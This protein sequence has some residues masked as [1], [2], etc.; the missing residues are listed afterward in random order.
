MTT[1]SP[2]DARTTRRD[3]PGPEPAGAEPPTVEPP[4]TEPHTTEPP[5]GASS[6]GETP[7]SRR[8]EETSDLETTATRRQG[9]LGLRGDDDTRVAREDAAAGEAT[10]TMPAAGAH[11]APGTART[12][13][14]A[15]LRER[16]R[17]RPETDGLLDG[18]TQAAPRSRAAAHWWSLL[19][20]LVL[21]PVAWYLVADAG[22]R[23]TL[24]EDSPWARGEVAP[25]ALVE[26]VAGLVV[27]AVVLL[28]ARW[29]SLGAQIL[30]LL[31]LLG[32]LAFVVVPARTAAFL[33]PAL[34][35]LQDRGDLGANVADHLVADG[36]AGRLALY[37]LGL[38]VIGVV[39]HGARRLGRA[40]ERT[41]TAYAQRTGR[42]ARRGNG[43]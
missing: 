35:W 12:P 9:F 27:T 28:A 21:A 33:E 38:L 31:V 1:P 3:R 42:S 22:A 41:R 8:W 5:T 37:G 32:G 30:G 43:R 17:E 20:V 6:T 26:L 39:S 10:R 19:L 34:A 25:A 2:D 23:L 7:P 11:A 4:T 18:A 14:D 16:W 36:S 29:S 40:E 15:A 13:E 24:G